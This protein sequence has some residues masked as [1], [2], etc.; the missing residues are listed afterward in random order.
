MYFAILF[1]MISS[2]LQIPTIKGFPCSRIKIA[3]TSLHPLSSNNMHFFNNA[4]ASPSPPEVL[5]TI[6]SH[7]ELEMAEGGYGA[8]RIVQENGHLENV[9]KAVAELINAASPM[10]V[11]LVES[12]TVAWTRAFYALADYI[13]DKAL[14]E[15]N[16]DQRVDLKTCINIKKNESR[17]ELS[18][19]L[20][21]Q[22][23]I[24]VSEAEY[25]ANVV[26]I[27]KYCS[28]QNQ[29]CGEKVN[30][31]MYTIPSATYHDETD[32]QEKSTGTVDVGKF[33][34]IL[35][36]CLPISALQ[37]VRLL[38]NRSASSSFD[39]DA[40]LNPADVAM[41]CVTHIPTNSGI[42]NPV[43]DLGNM[44]EKYNR[45]KKTSKP[46]IFYL[47]DACQSV[48]QIDVN[49]QKMHAHAIS[50]TGRKYMRGPRGT[51]FLY[52]KG[53]VANHISPSEVDHSAAQILL[54]HLATSPSP[55][56]TELATRAVNSDIDMKIEYNACARRFEY[57]ESNISTKLGLGAAI[58]YLDQIGGIDYVE[59]RIKFLAST[60]R[61]RLR[62]LDDRLIVY[63][64]RLSL[65]LCGIVCFSIDGIYPD[66]IKKFMGDSHRFNEERFELSIVPLTST[67]IDSS[68]T[69]TTDLIRVSLSYFNTE[70]EINIF[71]QK[72]KKLIYL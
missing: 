66:T 22:R 38:Q 6:I 17:Q 16:K 55:L 2:T 60:L 40:L 37:E 7:L 36:G 71:I 62:T 69:G 47:V 46:S 21:L 28:D 32:G 35:D 3:R 18:H 67:P 43:Y 1:L 44:I 59:K 45:M 9:Y 25:A 65:P 20:P 8:A 39:E 34:E 56:S 23:V 41:V 27:A 15:A 57:W 33:G 30:L 4:G 70:E 14:E 51:G 61:N 31:K 58:D 10:E 49:I 54:E 48:G 64:D 13:L 26:A 72:L 63:H 24:L 68:N 5:S 42:I 53:A 12:A 52:M 50:A 19:N 11:A 29:R